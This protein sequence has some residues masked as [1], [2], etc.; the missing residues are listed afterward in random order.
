MASVV[1]EDNSTSLTTFQSDPWS[2][3]AS[4]LIQ[5][6]IGGSMPVPSMER[7]YVEVVVALL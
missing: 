6:Q 5:L 2:H 4:R 7:N 1:L 3:S